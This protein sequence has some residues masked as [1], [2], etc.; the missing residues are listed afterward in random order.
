MDHRQL[1]SIDQKILITTCG[2]GWDGIGYHESQPRTGKIKKGKN[3]V[4]T[5]QIIQVDVKGQ[6]K[7][8]LT[9]SQL[10]LLC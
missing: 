2:L 10:C 7:V 4:R 6:Y 5:Q 9:L 8:D 3:R 1:S